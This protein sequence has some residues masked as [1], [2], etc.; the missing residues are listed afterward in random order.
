MALAHT[1]LLHPV[2]FVLFV[3]SHSCCVY[4]D[5]QLDSGPRLKPETPRS[6]YS[7]VVDDVLRLFS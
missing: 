4:A 3:C 6:Q 1:A 7:K 5:A 2:V